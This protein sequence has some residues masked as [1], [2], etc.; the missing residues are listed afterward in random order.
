[1][2]VRQ[3]ADAASEPHPDQTNCCPASRGSLITRGVIFG[4]VRVR[5]FLWIA[6]LA[7]LAISTV[8]L[9]STRWDAIQS[10]LAVRATSEVMQDLRSHPEAWQFHGLDWRPDPEGFVRPGGRGVALFKPSL[11]LVDY[12][13]EFLTRIEQNGVGWITRAA[14]AGNY[15]SIRLT[16]TSEG[17]RPFISLIRAAVI[18]GRPETTSRL[19]LTAMFHRTTPFRVATEVR[20][21]RFTVSVE[22]EIVDTWT[23]DRLPNGGAG[24]SVSSGESAR[25]FWM[26]L[27]W[28]TDVI[29]RMCALITNPQS[30]SM[31]GLRFGKTLRSTSEG[32]VDS[33]LDGTRRWAEEHVPKLLKGKAE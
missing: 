14:N 19:P 26:K 10:V 3:N 5:S 8:S 4:R 12:R 13:F 23:D 17:P 9:A 25:L 20:G 33:S 6:V 1:M 31:N 24:F 11:H 15:Y 32:A 18:R 29:G 27:S 2:G 30:G 16:M 22:D 21:D 28:N 7:M